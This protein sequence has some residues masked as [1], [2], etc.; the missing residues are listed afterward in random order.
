MEAKPSVKTLMD[1]VPVLMAHG[2]T[3]DRLV[4]AALE[5][6]R[7]QVIHASVWATGSYGSHRDQ[8][9]RGRAAIR[10]MFPGTVLKDSWDLVDEEFLATYNNTGRNPYAADHQAGKEG[11]PWWYNSLRFP[12]TEAAARW[13]ERVADGSFKGVDSHGKRRDYN[14]NW[15]LVDMTL[16][17]IALGSREDRTDAQ[18]LVDSSGYVEGLGVPGAP[19]PY[20]W[21]DE[22][23]RAVEE[24]ARVGGYASAASR[25]NPAGRTAQQNIDHNR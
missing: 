25:R 9:A 14:G 10:K 20:W 21:N 11:A 5:A 24:E 22:C 8:R 6:Q 3:G 7:Q 16:Y 17:R 12:G 19:L 18:L 2:V 4:A 13:R 15:Y 23:Q 1:L